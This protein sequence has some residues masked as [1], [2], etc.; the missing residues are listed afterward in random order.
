MSMNS[1]T[2]SS[3][4]SIVSD[5]VVSI[6]L[7]G[8]TIMFYTT[9]KNN[10]AM[11]SA[12]FAIIST[13]VLIKEISESMTKQAVTV[14]TDKPISQHQAAGLSLSNISPKILEKLNFH[15]FL[16]HH[17]DDFNHGQSIGQFRG[18]QIFEF[19]SDKHGVKYI[20]SRV[21]N[22]LDKLQNF[23]INSSSDEILIYPGIVYKKN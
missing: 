20:F 8:L 13:L 14:T 11:I 17:I 12:F 2:K 16:A 9:G 1:K 18:E 15:G 23:K 22:K 21:I 6:I 4:F 19:I 3:K 10:Y 7:I 5:A